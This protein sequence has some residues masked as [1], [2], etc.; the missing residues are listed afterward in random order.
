MKK[1]FFLLSLVLI[2]IA[3]LFSQDIS[4]NLS[5]RWNKGPYIL[6]SDSITQYPEL[7][8]SY[9]NTSNENLYFRK[10]TY[11]RNGL[12]DFLF[13]CATNWG[14]D[15]PEMYSD[16]DWL[17]KHINYEKFINRSINKYKNDK[18][19]VNIALE[20]PYY[21]A[22]WE[23][24]KEEEYDKERATDWS[25]E[26]LYIL[27]DY[28]SDSVYHNVDERKGHDL[29]FSLSD[30]TES[31]IM[32]DTINQFMFLKS[33]ETKEDVFNITSFDIVKG[34]YTFVLYSE[35]FPDSVFT[36][37]CE[38]E[39]LTLPKKVGEYKLYSGKFTSNSVTVKFE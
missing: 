33:G 11:Y 2:S 20:K 4:I 23:V 39:H 19:Y 24:V 14:V 16:P 12:P 21:C 17:E 26:T 27:N 9:S 37:W 34:T 1:H 6:N 25:N 7:V 28:L 8:V 38:G 31:S 18:F 13:I 32:N 36:G 15:D 10:F 30:I 29:F 3:N 22:N 5:I 35:Q